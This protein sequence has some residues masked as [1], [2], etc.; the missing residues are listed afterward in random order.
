M[1]RGCGVSNPSNTWRPMKVLLMHISAQ[2]KKDGGG[3]LCVCEGKEERGRRDA[4]WSTQPHYSLYRMAHPLHCSSNQPEFIQSPQ[5]ETEPLY[6]FKGD[7]WTDQSRAPFL[8]F[9]L[10]L[11]VVKNAP[12]ISVQNVVLHQQFE[13]RQ[14]KSEASCWDVWSGLMLHSL[15]ACDARSR[16]H[17]LQ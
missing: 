17:I 8:A 11:L 4:L 15:Q 14:N 16:T 7:R 2:S 9:L 13:G 5:S 10:K 12:M 6:V 3:C 1:W